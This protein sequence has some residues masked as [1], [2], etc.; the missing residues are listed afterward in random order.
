[1]GLVSVYCNAM[2][3]A[4]SGEPYDAVVAGGRITPKD[5]SEHTPTWQSDLGFKAAAELVLTV[6]A[7]GYITHE[8]ADK[9]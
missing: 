8:Y 6:R 7:C 5:F 9:A 4:S 2:Q 3:V 1:M